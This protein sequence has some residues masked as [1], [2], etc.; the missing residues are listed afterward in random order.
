MTNACSLEAR[1]FGES[2]VHLVG[3]VLIFLFLI[4]EFIWNKAFIIGR[5]QASTDRSSMVSLGTHP[6]NLCTYGR[7]A[8][9]KGLDS[10]GSPKLSIMTQ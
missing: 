1:K 10:Q 4:N 6:Y 3:N 5:A 2:L 7:Q 9:K 8:Y